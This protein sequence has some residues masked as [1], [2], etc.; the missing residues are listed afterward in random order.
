MEIIKSPSGFGFKSGQF[1]SI[2]HIE[3]YQKGQ[4]FKGTLAQDV[5]IGQPVILEGEV[6]AI[7]Q[8]VDFGRE[9]GNDFI[10]TTN[11]GQKCIIELLELAK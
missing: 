9:S 11:T 1:V 10:F 8:I 5:S 2:T 3:G 6:F 4:N 7:D